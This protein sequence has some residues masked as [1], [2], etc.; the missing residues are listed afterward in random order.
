MEV[1]AAAVDR[2][3]ETWNAG[4]SAPMTVRTPRHLA[5]FFD[6]LD[7]LEPGLVTCSQWRPDGNDTTPAAEYRAVGRKPGG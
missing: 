6:G 2:A 5:R 1:N 7:V 3:V 4:G